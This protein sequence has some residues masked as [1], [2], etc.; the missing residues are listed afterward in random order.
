MPILV[1][2]KGGTMRI[3]ELAEIIAL[4]ILTIF[5][6]FIFYHYVEKRK[7]HTVKQAICIIIALGIGFFLTRTNG[8]QHIWN[9]EANKITV[10]GYDNKRWAQYD[11]LNECYDYNRLIPHS[12]ENFD[13]VSDNNQIKGTTSPFWQI[14]HEQNPATFVVI[15]DSHAA[16]NYA[17][18]DTICKTH[19]VSG[20]LADTL[21][22]PFC[23]RTYGKATKSYSISNQKT[24]SF[25]HWLNHQKSVNSVIIIFSWYWVTNMLHAEST[26]EISTE[27]NMACMEQ[28]LINLKKLN[29]EAIVFA[30]LPRFKTDSI[31]M[32]ARFRK[33]WKL[34]GKFNEDYLVSRTDYLN[35][36]GKCISMLQDLERKGLCHIIDPTGPLFKEDNICYPFDDSG[37]I[38]IDCNH[39][40]VNT[41]IKVAKK[42]QDKLIPILKRNNIHN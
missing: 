31:L 40:S 16:M 27:D 41:S 25:I 34:T 13:I 8:L 39:Y 12:Q 24:D 1:L 6:G 32:Y 29:K 2:Y 17:G 38:F 21:I 7:Y 33:K 42:I 4:F 22:L 23:N 28:F 3:P 37:I 20:V 15:G 35:K 5:V 10:S 11:E 9:K 36:W 14:G 19:N 26:S 18:L 30:P